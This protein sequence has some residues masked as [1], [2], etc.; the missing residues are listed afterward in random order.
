MCKHSGSLESL[1]MFHEH[2]YQFETNV[3]Q[4]F[5]F[6]SYDILVVDLHAQM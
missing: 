5:L 6:M 2:Y 3:I 4:L 1:G